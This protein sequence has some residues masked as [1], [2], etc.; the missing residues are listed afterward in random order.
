MVTR[1]LI[2]HYESEVTELRMQ[3]RL[4]NSDVYGIPGPS[5]SD[6]KEDHK[7]EN[8]NGNDD[9]YSGSAQDSTAFD[10]CGINKNEIFFK[11]T[12]GEKRMRTEEADV[13]IFDQRHNKMSRMMGYD[14][15]DENEEMM[16]PERNLIADELLHNENSSI[17]PISSG[18]SESSSKKNNFIQKSSTQSQSVDIFEFNDPSP[19]QLPITSPKRIP[20]PRE[21]P[22]SGNS[23]SAFNNEKRIHDIEIIPL[24]N[25]STM[26]M[27]PSPSSITIT[28][29]NN[30]SSA[31]FFYKGSD[32]KSPLTDEKKSEKKKKR[33]R[34][35]G[36]DIPGFVKK[37]SSDSLGSSTS[38]SKKSPSNQMMGK[39]QASF[40]PMKSPLSDS[41]LDP[42]SSPK[43]KQKHQDFSDS[44]DELAF[45]NSFDQSQPQVR[46]QFI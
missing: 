3:K 38:P 34:E 37:K 20:T 22:S 4:Y 12:G 16:I 46:S 9:S 17:S 18:S 2:K 21:S 43:I 15:D 13:D 33:K 10:I 32:K 8:S 11:A 31:N 30:S 5:S 26:E 42:S 14:L 44:I 24:K 36:S 35:D 1:S 40:K 41:I 45:L 27:S 25:S 39:P 6:K 29:I 19:P 23:N 28:P 7:G